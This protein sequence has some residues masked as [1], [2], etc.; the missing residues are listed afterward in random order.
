MTARFHILTRYLVL[1]LSYLVLF[2]LSRLAFFCV[3]GSFSLPFA[4]VIKAFF[5]GAR[6]DLSLSATLA[7]APFFLAYA[8]EGF[9]AKKEPVRVI[10]AGLLSALTSIFVVLII[11]EFPFYQTYSSKLNHLFFEYMNQPKEMFVTLSGIRPA[12]IAMLLGIP[13]LYATARL[14]FAL[15]RKLFV[16]PATRLADRIISLVLVAA[17][18]IIFLRGGFQ[19]RPVNWGSAF[20]SGSNILNQTALNGQYNLFMHFQTFLEERGKKT[21]LRSYFSDE[22]ARNNILS[23]SRFEQESKES[24]FTGITGRPNIVII[25]MESFSGKYVGALGAKESLTPNFDRL[26]KDGVLFTSFYGN[27]TRTSRGLTAGL[28][29]FPPQPGVNLTKKVSAQQRVPSVAYYLE[30]EGYETVFL[31]AGDKEFEDMSGFFLN[32]GFRHF[33]GVSELAKGPTENPIGF[34]DHELFDKATV[35]FN[36]MQKP[37]FAAIM[38]LTNHG[39]YT[40]P[41]SYKPD[42]SLSKVLNAFKYSDWA[43]GRFMDEVSKQPYYKNTV[44]LI[45]GDHA[46]HSTDFDRQRF[47]IPLLVYSPMLKKPLR[48]DRTASQM[49]L[50]LTILHLAGSKVKDEDTSFWGKSLY[51]RKT[52]GWAYVLD[53]P[54]FGV[55]TPKYFYRESLGGDP[56]LFGTEMKEENNPKEKQLLGDYARSVLQYSDKLFFKSKAGTAWKAKPQ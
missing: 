19:R 5:I 40:L 41:S 35:L 31:Y 18:A 52:G 13:A 15:Y 50:P 4:D 55:I 53:D 23:F 14:S 1:M 3:F 21:T 46:S 45:T 28:C 27:A 42:P 29:S 20:F 47:H 37:F 9:T 36:G 24:L 51:E 16:F 48:D 32:S 56:R 11:L 10:A 30:K 33:Y 17:L 2:F 25:F 38:T 8:V 34:F 22:Q 43:L 44:F 49:D 7:S 26:S 12:M 39:P 54:Y 6:L